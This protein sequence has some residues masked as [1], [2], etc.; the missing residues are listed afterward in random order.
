LLAPPRPIG[1]VGVQEHEFHADP[2]A[3]AKTRLGN[4]GEPELLLHDDLGGYSWNVPKTDWL[5]IG[6]GT[7]HAKNVRAAWHH[8]R[9]YFQM[10]G[11]VPAGTEAELEAMKGYSYYLYHPAHLGG[12]ARMIP[13]GQGGAYLVGDSLGLAHPIT[14]EG[15]LPA[16]TSGRVLAEAILDEDAAS[17]PLR[18]AQHPVIMDYQRV[19][20]MRVAAAMLQKQVSG[21]PKGTKSNEKIKQ[22]LISSKTRMLVALGFGWLFSGKSLPTPQLIDVVLAAAE[23]WLRPNRA[24][25]H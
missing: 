14:A 13:N 20:R 22:G 23:A 21:S 8:A 5:N 1:P 11:H 25:H 2:D 3:I 10:A 15:I 19:F 4:D 9:A 6:S 16:V 18:L 7:L 17:Y 12:A 24:E